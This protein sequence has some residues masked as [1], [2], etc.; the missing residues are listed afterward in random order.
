MF[1]NKYFL[2]EISWEVCNQI[3][4]IYTV[5]KSK[6]AVC[7]KK[8]GS[9]YCLVG[10]YMSSQAELEF[11]SLKR[12]GRFGQACR[13][14]ES[15][16]IYTHYGRWLIPGKPYV[17]LIDYLKSFNKLNEYKYF[18]WKDHGIETY[19]E[20]DVNDA[21]IFGYLVVEFLL[22][23]IQ[24]VGSLDLAQDYIIDDVNKLIKSS[25]KSIFRYLPIVAHFH[26]WMSS[27]AIPEI[28]RR[29]LPISTIFTTHATLLGRYLSASDPNW[30]KYL[31]QINPHDA[32]KSR[33]IYPRYSIERLAAQKADLFTTVSNVT[34]NEAAYIL[35]KRPDLVLPNGINIQR[36]SSSVEFQNLHVIY[37]KRI[38]EFVI[39]HFFPSYSFDLDSTLYIFT[40]GRYE[41]HNK[42]IDLFIEALA[43]LN[44]FLKKH[45]NNLTVIAF[46]I[47]KA[48]TLSMNP[49]VLKNHIL[50][51]EMKN[52]ISQ[53]SEKAF[54]RIL[55]NI[56]AGK[57]PKLDDLFTDYE[58]IQLKRMIH[59]LKKNYYP[60]IVIHNLVDDANDP[61]LKQLRACNLINLP[62]DKVK[63][64]FHPE[65]LSVTN[66]LFGMDY[67]QFVRGT[68]LGVFPS[69]YEPWGYTPL[70][71]I[72]LGVPA[73]TSDL[74]GFG[75]FAKSMFKDY[76]K[77]GIFVVERRNKSF[78]ESAAQLTNFMYNILTL[79]RRERANLRNNTES[80]SKY[81]DWS[82]LIENYFIAHQQALTKLYK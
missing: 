2:V 51:N 48:P 28:K 29:Q 13:I 39:G 12:T 33:L 20:Q 15:K 66:P 36:Y 38:Q 82:S 79:S 76:K 40:S 26:E 44:Y 23:L 31:L 62:E 72:A 55:L 7:V 5:L 53:I 52:V 63:V 61:I 67:E 16:G 32:A 34:A 81:F 22:A 25:S 1:V 69:L 3:G 18:L 19:D 6:A 4:G 58:Q 14:L 71:C 56:I 42:G 47:T 45:R 27:V 46:I 70:E 41:Y 10:P 30:Y 65:F 11:E 49:E 50:L 60:P 77:R 24:S 54:E 37:K 8:L 80:T 35:G 78:S 68:H 74:S 9:R 64:V 17:I 57:M 59:S 75:E 21:V 73:I 43:R